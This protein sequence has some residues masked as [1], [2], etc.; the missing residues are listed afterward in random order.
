LFKQRFVN[1]PRARSLKNVPIF[2]RCTDRELRRIASL[3]TNLRV[4]AGSV[5]TVAS[6]P[7][8]EFF[9]IIQGTATVWREGVE[10]DVV[11]PGSF[12]GEVA[13]LNRGVRTATVVSNTDMELLVASLKE[14]RSSHFLVPPVME[15]MLAEMS[16]RLRRADEGWTENAT[17][18]QSNVRQITSLGNS[19]HSHAIQRPTAQHDRQEADT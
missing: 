13:L 3:T 12:F 18:A 19:S 10:L 1:S 16:E 7:G 17:C 4:E 15:L 2:S 11:G 8:T 14:F 5:L 6:E 9:V